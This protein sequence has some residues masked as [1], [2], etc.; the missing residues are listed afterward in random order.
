MEQHLNEDAR[1][2]LEVLRAAIAERRARE[3]AAIEE[4]KRTSNR[5]PF[6]IEVFQ[7]YY[8]PSLDIRERPIA[9]GDIKEYERKYY[10]LAPEEI[11]TLEQFADHLIFLHQNDAG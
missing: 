2:T 10:L 7:Q 11:R 9:V 5:E 4:A 1:R 6:D 3:D 8:D